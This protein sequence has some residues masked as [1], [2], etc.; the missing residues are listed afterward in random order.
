LESA[1]SIKNLFKKEA[2]EKLSLIWKAV[3]AIY[4]NVALRS[5]K[6]PNIIK[7]NLTSLCE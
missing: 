1:K 7:I 3:V 2:S 4:G 5:K 6:R